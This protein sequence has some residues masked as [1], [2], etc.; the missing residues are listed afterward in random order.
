MRHANTHYPVPEQEL[1]PLGIQQATVLAEKL[2]EFPIASVDT[3]MMVRSFQ[4]GDNIAADHDL[5]V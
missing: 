4:T 3:S 5:P 1:S 2:S